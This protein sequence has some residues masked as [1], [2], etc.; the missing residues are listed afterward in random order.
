MAESKKKEERKEEKDGL[1]Y[2]WQGYHG[3]VEVVK[4]PSL[5]GIPIR[6]VAIGT[7]H[8]VF[9]TYDGR[10]FACG[11]NDY[12]QLGVG[13]G[14]ENHAY[15]PVLISGL[16]GESIKD[17]ACGSNH[18]TAVTKSGQ[19]YCWGDSRQYQCAST[20]KKVTTPQL[21]NISKVNSEHCVHGVSL[22]DE[23]VT[24]VKVS[25]GSTHTVALS[26]AGEV[27]VWGSGEGLGTK[28]TSTASPVILERLVG[29]NVLGISCGFTHTL[30]VVERSLLD[31]SYSSVKTRRSRAS[32]TTTHKNLP[33]TCAKCNSEIYTYLETSD[34]CIISEEHLC[35]CDDSSETPASSGE[36]S[37]GE[38]VQKSRKSESCDDVF[39]SPEE[40][41]RKKSSDHSLSQTL[42]IVEDHSEET[43]EEDVWVKQDSSNTGVYPLENTAESH[44]MHK[45]P[46]SNK[47]AAGSSVRFVNEEEARKYLAEQYEDKKE[48]EEVPPQQETATSTTLGS[49]FSSVQMYP[50][51]VMGH[52]SSVPQQMSS[53]T[54]KAFTSITDRLG[55]TTDNKPKDNASESSG[56]G[57]NLFL[58]GFDT[59]EEDL[60]SPGVEDQGNRSSQETSFISDSSTDDSAERLSLRTI[61]AKQENLCKMVPCD[62]LPVITE[63]SDT[64]ITLET[65]VWSWG[66][67]N[68]GQLGHGDEIDR[69]QP[70][71]VRTLNGAKV[72]R[73]CGGG[74][75]S[76]ALTADSRVYSW[77]FNASGQL[78]RTDNTAKPCTIQLMDRCYVWDVAAG[79]KFSMFLMDRDGFQPEIHFVGKH[80]CRD[81]YV[82]VYKTNRLTHL[83]FLKQAGWVRAISAGE[84]NSACISCWSFT[85]FTA[86]LFEVAA[87]ERRFYSYL[88]RIVKSVVHPLKESSFFSTLDVFPY[89]SCT[90]NLL[91]A[92][93]NITNLI[94][95]NSVDLTSRIRSMDNFLEAN[96]FTKCEDIISEFKIFSISFADMLAIGGLEFLCKTGKPFFDTLDKDLQALL[97]GSK[98]SKKNMAEKLQILFDRPFS[99]V[100]EYCRLTEKL[101][102]N[103]EAEA[104]EYRLL[105]KVTLQWQTLKRTTSNEHKIATNTKSFWES[106]NFHKLIDAVKIPT[107]R[108]IRSS[109]DH[110]LS[111]YGGGRMSTNDFFLFNDLFVHAQYSTFRSYPLDTLWIETLEDDKQR[112]LISLIMPE[113]KLTLVA[114]DGNEKTEWLVALNSTINK[115]LSRQKSVSRRGSSDRLTPPDIRFANHQ[116]IRHTVFKGATYS[117]YWMTGKIHGFGEMKWADGRKYIGNFKEG[118]Q[119]GHGKLIL[120]QDDGSERTQEGYWRDGLLHGLAKVRYSNGDIYEGAFKDGQR[121]GHGIY[122]HGQHTSMAA[123]VYIG[124]W[125]SDKKQGYGIMDDVMKGEKYMGLWQEDIRQGGGIVVTLDGMYFE[126]NFTQD[127]LTGYGLMLTY[128]TSTY[129]GEFAGIT[130]LQ[131]KGK[132]TMPNHDTI[133]GTFSGSWNEGL[134]I[135][136]VFKKAAYS[137]VNKKKGHNNLSPIFGTMAVPASQRWEGMFQQCISVFRVKG[138]DQ[139]NTEKA[140]ENVAITLSK[141][142]KSIIEIHKN[143]N[144]KIKRILN[145]AEELETIPPHSK[146]RLTVEYYREIRQYLH[147]AFDLPFH[148]LGKLMEGLVD[149]FRAAYIGVGAHPRLLD[150]AVN[151]I[152]SFVYR[153]YKC[154]RILFPDLPENGGPI[155][156]EPETSEER[157]MTPEEDKSMVVSCGTLIHPILLPKIYPPL[158]DL[159]ALYNDKENEKYWERV[160]KLNKQGDVGLMAFLGI[161]QKFWLLDALLRDKSKSL[162]ALRDHCYLSCIETLQHIS[163][164]FSPKEKLEVIQKTFSEITKTVQESMGDVQMWCMDD[165]FPIFHYI[166]IRAQ[167]RHLGAEIHLIQDLMERHLENGELGIMFTMLHACYFQIQN[168]KIPGQG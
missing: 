89:K 159:Y 66:K 147:K 105:S 86:S 83:K 64:F 94:G 17:V 10:L 131:G 54:S 153:L 15:D 157:E 164:A 145:L 91:A 102:C 60:R 1:L 50:S 77:G 5:F 38:L 55:F 123:S 3:D 7:D 48:E 90:Q 158:F 155:L 137:E 69:N 103:Y 18:C 85:G 97:D 73:V 34:T 141:G 4:Y 88:N 160:R 52:I 149:V 2:M 75:H 108:L 76:L 59:S 82:P 23:D 67:N 132:L 80:P 93:E 42:K 161:D 166:V 114:S 106:L 37:E 165:L 68:K 96:F 117:G 95:E 29:R 125:V 109:R 41:S 39:E 115:D 135:N 63:T 122:R 104:A 168:E 126:G 144:N 11:S 12:G 140:W 128:D 151:E 19:V 150:H 112:N 111:L 152:T 24:I 110:P 121:H 9:L 71:V 36:K 62:Q 21:V 44:G 49:L 14:N 130:Q 162:S 156:I 8:S 78:A 46:G 101:A 133:E 79:E 136:G 154:V 120:K 163:T 13:T 33:K 127:K 107:R 31:D 124:E 129:E 51:D 84:D 27:W 81:L 26:D 119:H 74:Y 47:L 20:E 87:S 45:C 6:K 142:E 40:T 22:E 25:C 16:S 92:F 65:E 138:Q 61:Q 30:A 57:S 43:H 98:Y 167:I 72:V 32:E 148:P 35:Q 134:K 53:M 146:G 58:A 113:E 100:K 139:L 118:L 56:T 143:P 116:F 28:K 99:H 70:E